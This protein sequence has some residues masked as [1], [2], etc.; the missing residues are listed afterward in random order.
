MLLTRICG[1]LT[2]AMAFTVVAIFGASAPAAAT[3]CTTVVYTTAD[4]WVRIGSSV[5]ADAPYSERP[6]KPGAAR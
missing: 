5:T 2:G 4:G 1:H 6:T 3:H